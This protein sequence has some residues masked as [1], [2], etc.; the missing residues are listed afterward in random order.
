MKKILPLFLFFFVASVCI[1]DEI[2]SLYKEQLSNLYQNLKILVDEQVVLDNH[3][4]LVIRY[5]ASESNTTEMLA[6]KAQLGDGI[7]ETYT[8]ILALKIKIAES[9]KG[10]LPQ[11]VRNLE[12][13]NKLSDEAQLCVEEAMGK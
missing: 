12:K 3:A 7:R 8:K 10:T 6:R 2:E 5:G 13:E 11:W 1:A 9:N 4:R